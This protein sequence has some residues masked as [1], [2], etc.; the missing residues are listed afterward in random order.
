MPCGTE[1][2]LP[3]PTVGSR[4]GSKKPVEASCSLKAV[5][6][7]TCICCCVASFSTLKVVIYASKYHP[8]WCYSLEDYFSNIVVVFIFILFSYFA[9]AKIP[10]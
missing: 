6:L 3:P 5:R 2:E 9:I 7:V 8:A 10:V 1:R 4:K